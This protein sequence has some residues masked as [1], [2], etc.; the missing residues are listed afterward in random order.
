MNTAVQVFP[1]VIIA[2]VFN[3]E[4]AEYFEIEDAAVREAPKVSF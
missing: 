1:S 2:G 3:F 4:K